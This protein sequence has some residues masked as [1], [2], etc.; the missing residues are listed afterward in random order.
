MSG[1]RRLMT[2]M[3]P[4]RLYFPAASNPCWM[5]YV[6]T[7]NVRAEA[8]D[9][10]PVSEPPPH[11]A[12]TTVAASAIRRGELQPICEGWAVARSPPCRLTAAG[13]QR[14]DVIDLDVNEECLDVVLFGRPRPRRSQRLPHHG[15]GS[16]YILTRAFELDYKA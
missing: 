13:G 12:S 5:L 8:S 15:L 3:A 2:S 1:C 4:W 11:E 7:V 9:V 14:T 16:F 10:G 6:I